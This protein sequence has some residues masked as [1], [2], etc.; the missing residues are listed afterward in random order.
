MKKAAEKKSSKAKINSKRS[1]HLI[2]TLQND[3][4]E[5]K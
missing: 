2:E 5:I 4:A 3:K 1:N